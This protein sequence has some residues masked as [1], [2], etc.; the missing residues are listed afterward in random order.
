MWDD[1]PWM[2]LSHAFSLWLISLMASDDKLLLVLLAARVGRKRG[3]MNLEKTINKNMFEMSTP[4]REKNPLSTP[5]A[6]KTDPADPSSANPKQKLTAQFKRAITMMKQRSEPE[7]S[8][9]PSGQNSTSFTEKPLQSF[10]SSLLTSLIEEPVSCMDSSS[11]KSSS[12]V[13]IKPSMERSSSIQ[14]TDSSTTT[15]ATIVN[16]DPSV[17]V[18]Y[19]SNSSPTYPPNVV[20]KSLQQIHSSILQT[21]NQETTP[22]SSSLST[23]HPTSTSSSATST[24]DITILETLL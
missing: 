6:I 15:G 17:R 10:D 18:N 7:N 13:S 20:K 1:L 4:V 11:M 16:L 8:A 23:L 3:K 2:L 22:V 19:S 9:P 14:E 24:G 12:F 21:M 5:D